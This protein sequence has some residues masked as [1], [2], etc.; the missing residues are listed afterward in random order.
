[1]DGN[2]TISVKDIALIAVLASILFVQE[3]L[4][5][6][7]PGVQLSIFLMVLYSKKLGFTKA[8]I[9]IIL[10]IILDCFYMNSFSL[11]Y[12]PVMIVGWMLIP[13]T[14]C[15]IFKKVESPIILGLLGIMYAF[16]YCW[17]YM[18]PNYFFF[19][20]GPIAYLISDIIFE[21]ILAVCS[22]ITIVILYKPCS[23]LF[24]LLLSK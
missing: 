7:I 16:I 21:V 23:K 4:L 6:S 14:L 15:T 20:I 12:T 13:I 9:I 2:K 24:N 8:S 3:Q 19:N 1:M 11:F 5:T 17:I 22:F 18:I 10:Y